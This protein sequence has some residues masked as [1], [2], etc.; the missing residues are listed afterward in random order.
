MPGWVYSR[1]GIFGVLLALILVTTPFVGLPEPGKSVALNLIASW[2]VAGFTIFGLDALLR[3][4][5]ARARLPLER[6]LRAPL[7]LSITQVL[8]RSY[9]VAR[10]PIEVAAGK[11]AGMEQT[12]AALALA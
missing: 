5:Q 7:R 2:V 11:L 10:S 8:N 9:K 1:Q 4:M 12:T 3:G 6:T